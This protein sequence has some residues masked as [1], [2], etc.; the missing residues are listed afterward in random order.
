MREV[1]NYRYY[2][3]AL[4]IGCA[5][6]LFFKECS[7]ENINDWIKF[8]LG[9]KGV[10]IVLVLLAKRLIDYWNPKGKIDALAKIQRMTKNII[11]N[12]D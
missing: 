11:G 10:A 2:L 3:L 8:H 7:D 4:L 9:A 12:A 5:F 1:F 6:I